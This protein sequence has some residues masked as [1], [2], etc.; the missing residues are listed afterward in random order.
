MQWTMHRTMKINKCGDFNENIFLCN[1]LF[2]QAF[3]KNWEN[4]MFISDDAIKNKYKIA[5]D[6]I[7]QRQGPRA[8]AIQPL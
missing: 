7:W 8:A 6:H 4:V 1:F 2:L 5:F 3:N